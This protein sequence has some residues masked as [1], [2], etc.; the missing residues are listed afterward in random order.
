MLVGLG[1]LH[2]KRDAVDCPDYDHYRN[3]TPEYGVKYCQYQLNHLVEIDVYQNNCIQ[4]SS[5]FCNYSD[6]F[7]FAMPMVVIVPLL[8]Y[9]ST[10]RGDIYVYRNERSR[11]KMGNLRE[12]C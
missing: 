7:H 10:D 12:T 9:N 1:D 5:S 2:S 11:R 6:S 3:P 4:I 8:V